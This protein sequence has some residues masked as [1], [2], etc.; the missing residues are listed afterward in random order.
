MER[1]PC[2]CMGE[3]AAAGA[4]LTGIPLRGL[5]GTLW[6][7]IFCPVLPVR[8]KR[9]NICISNPTISILSEQGTTDVVA[10]HRQHLRTKHWQKTSI[11]KQH[12]VAKTTCLLLE[13]FF[14]N[15]IQYS[16]TWASQVKWFD[17]WLHSGC[18]F[19]RCGRCSAN[20]DSLPAVGCI[21]L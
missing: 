18:R 6:T 1:A 12:K 16:N 2:T 21:C 14:P 19:W 5:L 10:F 7:V 3:T 4:V 17:Q 9:G 15:K 13:F 8:K 11:K 20:A